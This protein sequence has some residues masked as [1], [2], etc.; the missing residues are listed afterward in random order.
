MKKYIQTQL[1][2]EYDS[3]DITSKVTRLMDE[4]QTRFPIKPVHPNRTSIRI[5]FVPESVPHEYNGFIMKMFDY[6][7]I[8]LTYEDRE[9]PTNAND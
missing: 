7:I 5:D 8:R 3:K 4:L 6:P 1:P 2:R 9:E